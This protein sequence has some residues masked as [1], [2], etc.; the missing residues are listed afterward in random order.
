[1]SKAEALTLRFCKAVITR[2]IQPQ[3]A[4]H[5]GTRLGLCLTYASLGAP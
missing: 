5:W 2:L 4:P 1:M 3:R